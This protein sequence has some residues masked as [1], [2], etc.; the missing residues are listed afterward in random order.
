MLSGWAA[1]LKQWGLN[2]VRQIRVGASRN[3]AS[4]ITNLQVR[5][6]LLPFQVNGAFRRHA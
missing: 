3:C 4:S 5:A 1:M 6:T 2:H